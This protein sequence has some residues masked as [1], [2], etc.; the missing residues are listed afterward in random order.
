MIKFSTLMRM[1]ASV[2]FLPYIDI[3]QASLRPGS[4]DSVELQSKWYRC[5]ARPFRR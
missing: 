1:I 2:M 5:S 4:K 3:S